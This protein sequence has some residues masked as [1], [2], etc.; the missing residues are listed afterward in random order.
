MRSGRLLIFVF[1]CSRGNLSAMKD[2]SQKQGGDTQAGC[3]LLALISSPVGIKKSWKRFIQDLGLPARFLHRDEY[4]EEFG[5]LLIPLPAVF[6]H[7]DTTRSLFIA[8][9]ELTREPA[10]EDL[11][12]LIR[13]KLGSLPS[14]VGG[15]A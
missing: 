6:F 4:E 7:N 13:E 5:E 8:A 10:V 2:Y 11:M 1:S 14:R 15:K 3:H 12:D 9:D